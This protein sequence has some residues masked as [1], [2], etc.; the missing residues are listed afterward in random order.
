MLNG[1]ELPHHTVDLKVSAVRISQSFRFHY[2]DLRYV[3]PAR[4]QSVQCALLA[5]EN[6]EIGLEHFHH[7]YNMF[8]VSEIKD[9]IRVAA[10]D[11]A[12]SRVDILTDEINLKY[13]N[14]V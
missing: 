7:H 8:I 2:S 6:A 14:K 4:A 9:Q 12:S 13:S 11:I 3:V 10:E 5:D 1:R